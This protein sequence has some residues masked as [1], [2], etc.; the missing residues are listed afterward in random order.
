MMHRNWQKISK[1]AGFKAPCAS[2]KRELGYWWGHETVEDREKALQLKEDA[3]VMRLT[4]PHENTALAERN[5]AT[6]VP[7]R[8][9]KEEKAMHGIQYNLE[10]FNWA[11]YYS[12]VNFPHSFRGYLKH[13]H[14]HEANKRIDAYKKL[15]FGQRFIRERVMALGPDLAAASFLLGRNCRVRF[16]DKEAWF[17]YQQSDTIPVT[18]EDDWYIE[19]I[20]ASCSNLIYEGIQN[21]R[22]LI[23]LKSFN[24]SYSPHI[25]NW[26][27]DRIT[28]EFQDS[29]QE[30]D[31]SGCKLINI[32]GLESLWRLRKLK[33][34]TLKDMD[35]IP[36]LNLLCLMLVEEFPDLEIR[37][38]DYENPKLLEGTSD[39]HLLDEFDRML[40]TSGEKIEPQS[41]V[42]PAEFPKNLGKTLEESNNSSVNLKAANPN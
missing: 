40:L 38:V 31:L 35:H 32:S 30:L 36:D 25:D 18:W 20:D 7:L 26:C 9:A 17:A 34:L 15:I 5:P 41:V 1:H 6:Y 37:G 29:L 21:L 4:S 3:K 8:V 24:I 27:L 22:N 10:N 28:G 33:V 23:F 12:F 19:S 42:I 16:K 39:Q 14:Y 2:V 13:P 11:N